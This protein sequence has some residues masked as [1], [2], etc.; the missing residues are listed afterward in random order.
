M[1]SPVH[2]K[3]ELAIRGLRLGEDLRGDDLFR[4]PVGARDYASR[5]LELLLPEEI[6]ANCPVGTAAS[7]HSP[8]VLNVEND[9]FML[10]RENVG[11]DREETVPVKVVPQ[12]A[13]Y[14]KKTSHGTPMWQVA[15]VHG[16]YISIDPASTCGFAVQGM[17]CK[18]CTLEGAQTKS[19]PSAR[20]VDEVLEVVRAAFEEGV[21]EFVYFN[22]GYFEAEDGGFAFLQPYVEA[23]K[24]RFDTLVAVQTNPPKTNG[25]ID[26]TYASGVDALSYSVEIY[27]PAILSSIC[28]GRDELIG[29]ERY[30]E[31]LEHAAKI[32]PSGTVWSD[33]VVGLE[34]AESTRAGIEHLV[35]LGVLP[36]L[37]LFRPLDETALKDYPLPDPDEVAPLYALLYKTVKDAGI[38]VQWMR[39][40]GY[41]IT[42]IE[43]RFFA[44]ED[45]RLDVAVSSFYRSRLGGRAARSLSRLRRRLRVKQ[46]SESFDSSQL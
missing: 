19:A 10:T 29:R 20:P 13:F 18:F 27:D 35:S 37:S 12:P 14:A 43:A 16:G 34:P 9:R 6:L 28:R 24:Q 45:A 3:L 25:W 22:T 23:V 42:P 2:L 8:F 40:L 1:L 11:A 33:L 32:F 5:D 41:T 17:A 15:T 46:V 36:V 38:S 44:G 26:R 30:Y 39:D 21:V 4:R 31:A 7:S